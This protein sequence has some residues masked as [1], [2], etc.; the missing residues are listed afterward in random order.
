MTK[1]DI[2]TRIFGRLTVTGDS[3]QRSRGEVIWSCLCQCGIT[4]T[5]T[6]SN[7]RSGNT[8]SCG[9][10]Q[11][12]TTSKRFRS[13]GKTSKR[14]YNIW[15]AMLARCNNPKNNRYRYYGDRGIT[16]CEG[17]KSFENFYADMGEPPIGLTLDRID[18][19]GNYCKENCR[20]VTMVEQANNKT[21]N[22]LIAYKNEVKTIAEWER[23][24]GFPRSLIWQRLERLGWSVDKT[25]TTPVRVK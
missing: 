16:V 6:T 1:I 23:E 22:H 20:W 3:G 5:V 15:C 10:F 7:L 12:E 14:V 24:L 18:I 4:C 19:D 21:N 11:R 9:C 2:T 13:H 25:F 8:T 17:W